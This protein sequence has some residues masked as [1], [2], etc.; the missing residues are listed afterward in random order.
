[1]KRKAKR[2]V[3]SCDERVAYVGLR[4]EMRLLR[5]ST[6]LIAKTQVNNFFKVNVNVSDLIILSVTIGN[7]LAYQNNRKF[8]TKDADNDAV[9]DQSCAALRGAWWY[10]DNC[11]ES[12]LNNNYLEGAGPTNRGI[13]W[14]NFDRKQM[15]IKRTEMKMRPVGHSEE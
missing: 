14:R 13:I 11:V 5:Y 9:G 10:G 8:S 3:L 12:D 6:F 2:S 7:F 4:N 1:M 15:S